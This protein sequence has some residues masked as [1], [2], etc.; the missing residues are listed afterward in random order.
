MIREAV[1]SLSQVNDSHAGTVPKLKGP[2][3]RLETD[4]LGNV[5]WVAI[6]AGAAGTP[7]GTADSFQRKVDATNFGGTSWIAV[8]G[9]AGLYAGL[10]NSSAS[11]YIGLGSAT[12][13]APGFVRVGVGASAG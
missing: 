6:P 10:L 4:S 11:A 13:A 9:G 8:D 7:Q 5:D 3:R 1:L 12:V 2:N